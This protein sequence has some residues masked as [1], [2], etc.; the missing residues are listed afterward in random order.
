[1]LFDGFIP[2]LAGQYDSGTGGFYY[3]QSAKGNPSFVPDIESTSQGLNIL[4][5]NNIL[6]NMS[7]D[8]KNQMIAFFQGKQHVRSGYFYD[9]N[10]AMKKDEVMVH[11][12]LSYTKGSLSK[13][14]SSP[15]YQLPLHAKSAPE[16]VTSTQSYLEK[17]KSIDLSNS[18][19]GCDLLAT[20]CVYIGDMDE[21]EQRPF[22]DE[23]VAYLESIQDPETGLW[24]EGSLY[25]RISGTFKLHTFYSKFNIPM[26]NTDK[27]YQSILT[28]LRTEEAEDM[29]YIRNPINLLA[30]MKPNISREELIEMI[31]ITAH[32][33]KKLKRADGGFS[34]ELGNSPTA[35]NVAQVKDGA[36]PDMPEAVHLSE[37]LYE[38]DMNA[39]TQAVLIRMQCYELAGEE[40]APVYGSSNFYKLIQ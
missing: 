29:C 10:P 30:Y 32:N 1:M 4:I 17:W 31:D 6:E 16:Y 36:Y 39:S 18:W 22:L 19:R 5:R 15:K 27:I 20:S 38:G 3:A 33:M 14:G 23:A 7:E 40:C 12:A 13:L 9:E 25:V 26:P 34:R 28:C 35:P 8:Q 37:G 2:W 21:K 11:R 24:G